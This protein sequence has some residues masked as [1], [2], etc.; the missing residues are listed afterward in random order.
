MGLEG[1]P[2]YV[3]IQ[4]IQTLI[5]HKSVLSKREMEIFCLLAEE[6]Q[7]VE[8]ARLLN[9]SPHTVSVHRK[10]ILRKTNTNSVLQL[11]KLGLEKG[12]I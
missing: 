12:W 11:L 9:I 6:Y 3:D 1:E 10:N 4:P 2:S 7:T 8:I 5:P